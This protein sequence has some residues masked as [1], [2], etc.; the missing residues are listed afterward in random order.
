MHSQTGGQSMYYP[1]FV[2]GKNADKIKCTFNRIHIEPNENE[3]PRKGICLVNK[4]CINWLM[5]SK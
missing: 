3:S 5:H 2:A 4:N 1:A